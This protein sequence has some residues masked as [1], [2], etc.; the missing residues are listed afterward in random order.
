MLSP[1]EFE[2]G[3]LND[4]KPN[5]ILLRA[6]DPRDKILVVGNEGARF[7]IFIERNFEY[8]DYKENNYYRGL[9]IQDVKFEVDET[10]IGGLNTASEPLGAIIASRTMLKIRAVQAERFRSQSSIPIY[11]KEDNN[12][13]VDRIFFKRWSIYINSDG[14]KKIIHS[15]NTDEI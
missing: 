2:V 1:H 12:Y 11:G 6:E 5:S 14:E 9:I 10:S 4:A 15:V 13:S 8:F 7:A 3:S